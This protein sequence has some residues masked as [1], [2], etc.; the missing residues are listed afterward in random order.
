MLTYVKNRKKIAYS[1]VK[2]HSP[3]TSTPLSPKTPRRNWRKG[4]TWKKV[5][6]PFSTT[7]FVLVFSSCVQTGCSTG[8]APC[9]WHT[10]DRAA[11]SSGVRRGYRGSWLPW[12]E[13]QVPGPGPCRRTNHKNVLTG[14]NESTQ[15]KMR[16][17]WAGIT[18]IWHFVFSWNLM[19]MRQIMT[20]TSLTYLAVVFLIQSSH[21][22][23]PQNGIWTIYQARQMYYQSFT[24]VRTDSET[25]CVQCGSVTHLALV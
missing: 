20:V 9:H 16:W 19:W 10:S 6:K 17:N 4:N 5:G 12:T 11:A 8:P 1:H 7:L 2:S 24:Q 22:I 18:N 23:P 25:S 15:S 3:A 13:L 14:W 21:S